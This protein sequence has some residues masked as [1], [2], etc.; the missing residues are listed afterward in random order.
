MKEFF[1]GELKP[2]LCSKA[3][4]DDNAQ[5]NDFRDKV[6]AFAV[7]APIEKPDKPN[8]QLIPKS[9]R[10]STMPLKFLSLNQIRTPFARGFAYEACKNRWLLELIFGQYKA[11]LEAN[12]TRVQREYSVICSEFIN[13]LCGIITSRMIKTEKETGLLNEL[14]YGSTIKDLNGALREL[15]VHI[16]DLYWVHTT[17]KTKLILT[18]LGLT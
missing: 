10:K 14:S 3:K 1:G 16:E 13:F 5:I 9:V 4:A 7:G 11:G 6:R 18:K 8:I 15:N 2:I 12:Q 17:L